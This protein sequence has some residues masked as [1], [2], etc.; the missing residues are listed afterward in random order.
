M[1]EKRNRLTSADSSRFINLLASLPIYTSDLDLSMHEISTTART[2]QLTSYDAIYLLLAMHEGLSI[3][4][5]DIALIKACAE[6][7]VEIYN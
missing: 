5:K 1:S 4:T 2:Y 7:G 3:A 6:N